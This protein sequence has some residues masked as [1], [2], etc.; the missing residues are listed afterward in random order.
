MDAV[1][2]LHP[3]IVADTKGPPN[4]WDGGA[5]IA[6]TLRGLVTPR[7]RWVWLPMPAF[8][9]E[10]PERGPILIDTGFDAG[11]ATD[12]AA[13]LGRLAARIFSPI[14]FSPAGGHHRPAAGPGRRAR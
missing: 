11:V 6:G 7:S 1:V 13:N 8:L 4:Y 14:R 9:I 5:G 10:H 12:P 3:M 2:K